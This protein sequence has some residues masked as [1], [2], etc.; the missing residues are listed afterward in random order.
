LMSSRVRAASFSLYAMGWCWTVKLMKR[1]HIKY[2]RNG[3]KN[4]ARAGS[5]RRIVV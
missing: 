2:K 3:N 1:A 5:F 4:G